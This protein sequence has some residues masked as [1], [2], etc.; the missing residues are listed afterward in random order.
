MTDVA[1]AP[2]G[3]QLRR[4][5]PP[6]VGTLTAVSLGLSLAM[7]CLIVTARAMALAGVRSLPLIAVGGSGLLAATVFASLGRREV[8]HLRVAA[9]TAPEWTLMAIAV[10]A[11][12]MIASRTFHL[13][14]FAPTTF[15][16]DAAHHAG[17]VA[18]MVEHGRIPSG[19]Q[20][21]LTTIS[22]YPI[23]G[24][25][26]PAMA[27]AVT[28]LEPI[29]SLWLT[30]LATVTLQWPLTAVICRS[31]SRDR[32]WALA[33]VPMLVMILAWRFTIGLA[34]WDFFF[35]QLVSL[36]TAVAGV[37]VVAAATAVDSPTRRWAPAAAVFAA[38]ALFTYPQ[39]A[40]IVPLAAA[41]ALVTR[42]YSRRPARRTVLLTGLGALVVVGATLALLDSQNY[43]TPQALLGSGEGSVTAPSM[44]TL[45]GWT[46]AALAIFG[47]CVL[48]GRARRRLAAAGAVLAASVGAPI[49]GFGLWAAQRGV[50]F[51][52]DVTSYRIVKNVYSA[53]PFGAVLA[54][55]AVGWAFERR[56]PTP[57]RAHA[58]PFGQAAVASRRSRTGLML[59]ATAIAVL[60]VASRPQ[61]LSGVAVPL[62]TRDAAELGSWAR[63]HLDVRTVGIAGPGLEP[64]T[65]WFAA[66]LRP[67]PAD[68]PNLDAS[69]AV[70]G[71]LRGSAP[72]GTPITLASTRWAAWPEGPSTEAYL[73]V[74]G[75]PLL[76][77][78]LGRPG[79][80]V[81]RRQGNAAILK[82]SGRATSGGSP[83][84]RPEQGAEGLP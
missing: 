22:D 29:T 39:Q 59:G 1:V 82:R 17:L 20:P 60:A 80:T 52:L 21:E 28:G 33:A 75:L 34:T 79:V 6:I 37:A 10:A 49:L 30:A 46:P 53:L 25:V 44:R 7:A 50:V 66:L 67:I 14:L 24:H 83:I 13:S 71:Y 38:A 68:P 26:V 23:W 12:W 77:G 19:I 63:T 69:T 43:L 73:L 51:H 35:A 62:V 54:G 84:G 70:A 3:A 57:R 42:R 78:Y 48:L 11:G 40:V 27:S 41:G 72:D 15:T 47:G 32:S 4:A 9:P 65:L 58:G 16:V 81:V 74:S 56:D 76:N 5:N 31:T 45:G 2:L 55:V 61:P 64:Y 18:W 8:R 36:F